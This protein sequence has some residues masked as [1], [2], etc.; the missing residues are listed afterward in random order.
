MQLSGHQRVL[1]AKRSRR[2]G[3]VKGDPS[4][5]RKGRAKHETED[6]DD[7][8]TKSSERDI[9]ASDTAAR[10]IRSGRDLPAVTIARWSTHVDI[11]AFA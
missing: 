4:C 7:V 8:L 10:G 5:T 1:S 11:R 6:E 2:P 9:G 3:G